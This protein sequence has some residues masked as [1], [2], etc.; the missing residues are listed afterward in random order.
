MLGVSVAT[1]S[2]RYTYLDLHAK[3]WARWDWRLLRLFPQT[4]Q[5][6][7]DVDIPVDWDN[8]Q[9]DEKITQIL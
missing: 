5:Q 9:S 3:F 8:V 7:L 1:A 2:T 6:A 4:T